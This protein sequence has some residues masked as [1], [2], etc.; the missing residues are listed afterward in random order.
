MV[1]GENF[2][3]FWTEHSQYVLEREVLKDRQSSL[4]TR[5]SNSQKELD[6]L[7]RTNVYS[8]RFS[9]LFLP[10][11]PLP[12]ANYP[13]LFDDCVDDAFCIGQESTLGTI[14]SLR[15]GRLPSISPAV[16]WTEINAALGHTL[17]LLHTISIK[18]GMRG[19]FKGWKLC[20]MGSFSR[21]IKLEEEGK[22]GES[23]EL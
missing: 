8:K 20:C 6:K 3:R 18:F 13:P 7:Q 5:L 14:N 10:P 2:F 21:I 22:E 1:S 15:L 17:L 11:S 19:G 16:E 12:Q 23:Y 9:S 4:I